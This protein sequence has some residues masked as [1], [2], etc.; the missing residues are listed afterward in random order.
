MTPLLLSL[1][2][3]AD[4]P[5][6][7]LTPMQ[8]RTANLMLD[9]CDRDRELLELRTLEVAQ[10][11]AALATSERLRDIAEADRADLLRLDSLRVARIET[12]AETIARE[13]R[14]RM[15]RERWAWI[16]GALAAVETAIIAGWALTR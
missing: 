11:E 8:V 6:V 16:A 5:A 12:L 1:T 13:Q 3:L 10:F 15:V 2:L 14:K 7:Y 9:E 4:T